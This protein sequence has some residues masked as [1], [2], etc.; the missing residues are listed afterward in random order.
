METFEKLV[1]QLKSDTAVDRDYAVEDLIEL[2]DLNAIKVIAEC[3]PH[4]PTLQVRETMLAALNTLCTSVVEPIVP[5]LYLDN[6]QI[7]NGAV[8]ILCESGEGV[9][10][11]LDRLSG[12]D[13]KDVRKFALDALKGKR[14]ASAIA[15]LQRALDD[16][17]ANV[18]IT[19]V[20]YLGDI[21]DRKSAPKILSILKKEPTL[22][23][24][25]SCLEALSKMDDIE[26][27][28]EALKVYVEPQAISLMILFP[29]LKL[30]GKAGSS[31]DFPLLRTLITTHGV[32][33]AKELID[34]I[35]H[36]CIRE[37]I[38]ELPQDLF[39]LLKNLSEQVSSP[40]LKYEI[41]QFL[42][43]SDNDTTRLDTARTNLNS[44]EI[45][46]QMS[47]LEVIME[48]GTEEDMEP[49]EAMAEN[50]DDDDLLEMLG[51]AVAA[52]SGRAS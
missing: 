17:D 31:K 12:D 19:A 24:I 11:I 33:F 20:E 30:L 8:D 25:V 42:Q 23:M 35:E 6:A 39:E 32:M 29:Y 18:K 3:L 16:D 44:G 14:S 51:E 48:Y 7:R 5:L 28:K 9:I 41:T 10:R 52:I 1:A 4:E 15:I 40:P 26:T 21:E 37:S 47:A 46:L 27:S 2:G 22:M 38:E 45:M 49:L 43:K 13:N 36:I 50:T 34:A